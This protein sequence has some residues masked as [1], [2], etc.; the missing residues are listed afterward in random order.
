MLL[1]VTNGALEG[2]GAKLMLSPAKML[3]RKRLGSKNAVGGRLLW[4]PRRRGL[5]IT[6]LTSIYLLL[7]IFFFFSY[8][9]YYSPKDKQP[10]ELSGRFGSRDRRDARTWAQVYPREYTCE[11]IS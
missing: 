3:K 11:E 6:I 9:Y 4:G 10:K 7:Y 8:L 1:K 2:R 5:N